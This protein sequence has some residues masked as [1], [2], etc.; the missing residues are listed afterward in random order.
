[1]YL[2]IILTNVI[3]QWKPVI[4]TKIFSRLVWYWSAHIAKTLKHNTS[5]TLIK[6]PS[7]NLISPMFYVVKI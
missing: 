4:S 5:N 7:N 3:T 6:V 1:L 2:E